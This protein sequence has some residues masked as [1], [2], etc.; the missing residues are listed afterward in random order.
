[1]VTTAVTMAAVEVEKPRWST[2]RVGRKPMT[3]Y[4]QQE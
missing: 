2:C 3:V 1:M 4:H